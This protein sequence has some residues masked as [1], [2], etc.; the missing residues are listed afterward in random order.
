MRALGKMSGAGSAEP[1]PYPVKIVLLGKSGID[2]K[3]SV[4]ARYLYGSIGECPPVTEG[5]S[6][7]TKTVKVDGNTFNLEIW[8]LYML[9][10]TL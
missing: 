4:L 7:F 1:D 2:A 8:G 3:S 10:I 6:S 9:C 5:S